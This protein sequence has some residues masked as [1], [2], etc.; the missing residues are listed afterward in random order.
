MPNTNDQSER[1]LKYRTLNTGLMSRF[2]GHRVLGT[3]SF[4]APS[5]EPEKN[6]PE[7]LNRSS[8]SAFVQHIVSDSE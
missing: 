2:H 1:D 5:P 8:M 7:C 3:H 4:K 6:E